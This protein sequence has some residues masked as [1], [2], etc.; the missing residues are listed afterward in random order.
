MYGNKYSG[1]QIIQG[2]P[3]IWL[4]NVGFIEAKKVEEFKVGDKIAYNGGYTST[5]IGI[6]KVTPQYLQF[7]TQE[8]GKEI[9]HSK[10]KIGTYKPFSRIDGRHW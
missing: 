6:K 3:A 9:F 7:D 10:V 2:K 8:E 1:M 5:V 4:Q